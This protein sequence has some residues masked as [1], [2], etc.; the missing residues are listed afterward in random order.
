MQIIILA[1]LFYFSTLLFLID[2][3]LG[4]SIALLLNSIV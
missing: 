3:I 1:N 2:I 4:V